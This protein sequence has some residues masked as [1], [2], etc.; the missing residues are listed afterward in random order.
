LPDQPDSAGA[1]GGVLPTGGVDFSTLPDQP[2]GQAAAEGFIPSSFHRVMNDVRRF[3]TETGKY[4]FNGLQGLA[5]NQ[6]ENLTHPTE[7]DDFTRRALLATGGI[8]QSREQQ[9]NAAAT[10]RQMA[11]YWRDRSAQID[12]ESG[13]DPA[14]AQTWDARISGALGQGAAMAGESLIPGAGLPLMAT[15][16]ALAT[17]AESLNAGRSQEQ[18]DSDAARSL[19]GLAI[20]GGANKVAALGVAKILPK[21]INNPGKLATFMGQFLGQDTANE[22]SSA[23]IRA[24]GAAENAPPGQK[25]EA[26]KAA[27]TNWNLESG[28]LNAVYAGV[29][30]AHAA[31]KAVIAAD[32]SNALEG[33]QVPKPMD[34]V[35]PEMPVQQVEPIPL[36]PEQQEARYAPPPLA[37]G[38]QGRVETEPI[39]SKVTLGETTQREAPTGSTPIEA[40]A[41]SD[42]G[43]FDAA[44]ADI[45]AR[46]SAQALG[47]GA[48]GAPILEPPPAVAAGVS[49]AKPTLIAEPE[50]PDRD[51][52]VEG[53]QRLNVPKKKAEQ[54]VDAAIAAAKQT[55]QPLNSN[56]IFNYAF[57]KSQNQPA[58]FPYR[59]TE[60]P[61]EPP[62]QESFESAAD[63]PQKMR[64]HIKTIKR[65]TKI[66]GDVKEQVSSFY[67]PISE[68]EVNL[69]ANNTINTM[70]LEAAYNHY[71]DTARG[72]AESNALGYNLAERLTHIDPDKAVAIGNRM[73]E[74]QTDPAQALWY[75]STIAKTSPEGLARQARKIVA[76][77]VANDPAKVRLMAEIERLQ[78]Q[79]AA[80]KEGS[81]EKQTATN[82]VLRQLKDKGVLQR[83]VSARTLQNLI[84]RNTEGKL[85]TDQ[86]QEALGR[87]FRVPVVTSQ[88]L[89]DIRAAQEAWSK[90]TDPALKFVKGA[91]MM[92]AVYS[93]VPASF[94]QKARALSVGLMI[95]HGKLPVRIGVSNAINM[96]GQTGVDVIKNTLL[97]DPINLLLGRGTITGAQL[98]AQVRGLAEPYRVFRAGQLEAKAEGLTNPKS[99]V[100]GAKTLI[101]YANI[102]TRGIQDPTD[103]RRLHVLDSRTG[104]MFENAIA[105]A[106]NIVPL[107]FWDAA[108]KGSIARNMKKAQLRGETMP[109][110]NDDIL[111]QAFV[112]ANAAIFRNPTLIGKTMANIARGLNLGK[113]YG[114][115]TATAPF[116]TVPGAMLT[117]GATW[118]PIGYIRALYKA[119]PLLAGKEVDGKAI[120][121][122]LIKGTIGTGSTFLTGL[123]LH[124]LGV[125]TGAPENDRELDALR[126]SMKWGSYRVNVS[127]LKRR[128]VSGD[129][130]SKSELPQDGDLIVNYAWAEPVAFGVAMGADWDAHKEKAVQQARKGQLAENPYFAAASAGVG[131]LTDAPLMQGVSRFF[132]DSKDRGWEYA[133]A[134]LPFNVAQNFLPSLARQTRD[135]MDNKV[136]ETRGQVSQDPFAGFAEQQANKILV[137][138]PGISKKYPPRYDVTGEATRRFDYGNNSVINTYFNPAQ[139]NRFKADPGL[140]EMFRLYQARVNAPDIPKS[141]T[142]PDGQK[143]QVVVPLETTKSLPPSVDRHITINGQ[144]MALTNQQIADYQQYVSKVGGAVVGQLLS[145][146]AFAREPDMQKTATIAEVFSKV[147]DAAK[148]E[149]FGQAPIKVSISPGGLF[150]EPKLDITQADVLEMIMQSRG[151]QQGFR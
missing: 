131:T 73:A 89:N 40:R 3:G 105:V 58:K 115:G 27:L 2:L 141:I 59:P 7:A 111:A 39:E 25:L 90:E 147:N 43:S 142:L 122:S 136:R 37:G 52:I 86:L 72:T 75:L 57:R 81:P 64:G 103:M 95:F 48:S 87:A 97:G 69:K 50:E 28:A 15:H 10:Y 144:Q 82:I 107:S 70:G 137:Q 47:V 120:A 32:V 65:M 45:A 106:H 35:T 63:N 20:F 8:P 71:M 4:I 102:R 128:M 29:G 100:E 149:L 98:A 125:L 41:E 146:P 112:D 133:A 19:I 150:T 121:D 11:S 60:P 33:V 110:P 38:A 9:V 23:A 74:V 127:E 30:A 46:T 12:Q 77:Q 13:V 6:V 42:A 85:S 17:K 68:P 139:W 62:A 114:V 116:T 79:L 96:L 113:P 1:A 91:R 18:A 24:W 124:H 108:F 123:W 148:V 67:D 51:Q 118:T 31:G 80:F 126:N 138:L 14:L 109:V 56:D 140:R 101:D 34:Q 135:Y 99:M 117:E 5:E 94:L 151:R 78:R 26:A 61:V 92:D 130:S 22:A 16:G 49:P 132:T 129:W 36:T 119:M 104:R 88:W 145:S 53:L 93:R 44:A 55:K 83:E 134:S 54:S 143:V 84:K 21:V 66:T 76:D